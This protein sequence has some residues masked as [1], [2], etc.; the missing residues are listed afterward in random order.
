M[1]QDLEVTNFSSVCSKS[2]Y[3]SL[4]KIQ[5]KNCSLFLKIPIQEQILSLASKSL[6]YTLTQGYRN[7]KCASTSRKCNLLG[8]DCVQGFCTGC[9]RV[10]SDYSGFSSVTGLSGDVGRGPNSVINLLVFAFVQFL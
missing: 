5:N 6:T 9:L 8:R 2:K 1:I 10:A 3:F 4:E 7:S